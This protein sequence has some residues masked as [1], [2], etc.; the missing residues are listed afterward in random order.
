MAPENLVRV[1]GPDH[2]PSFR[3]DLSLCGRSMAA[4]EGANKQLA[5]EG[6]AKKVCAFA[7]KSV[8]CMHCFGCGCVMMR[9]IK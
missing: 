4:E 1:G 3:C 7:F 6:A 5:K 9:Q 2:A 8:E